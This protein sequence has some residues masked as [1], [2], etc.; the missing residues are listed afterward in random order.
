MKKLFLILF[1]LSVQAQNNPPVPVTTQSLQDVV[2]ERRLTANAEVTARNAS[3]LSAE[4]NAVVKAIHADSG[5]PIS[6]DQLLISLDDTDLQLQLEQAQANLQ[7]ARARLTQ[8]ELRLERANQ[9]NQSQYISADDLLSRETDV[10]V[11]KADLQSL[12][13]AQKVAVRNLSKTRILAPFE[14]VVSDRQAQ[15]GQWL[16][17]GAPMLSLVQTS[18]PQ[19]VAKI[20]SHLA[21]ELPNADQLMFV[22]QQ[23]VTP[24]KLLQLSPVIDDL[25]GVQTARFSSSESVQIGLTGE[26]VW[27]LKGRLLPAD[28]VVKREGQLGVFLAEGEV[29]RFQPLAG[30]QEGRPVPLNEVPDWQVIIG[31]RERLQDQ[32]AIR[33]K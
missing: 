22:Q 7:A 12:R 25:A 14:G 11:L 15:L 10:A 1:S 2:I 9:L 3:T 18:E 27:I 16:S 32:Q 4:V 33:V 20:P 23:Q 17:V 21:A 19:I 13:I 31:G 30:A 24:V 6:K 28:L 5:D 8:A 26:L 29:A